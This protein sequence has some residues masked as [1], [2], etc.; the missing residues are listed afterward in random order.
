MINDNV[1]CDH[2]IEEDCTYHGGV[3]HNHNPGSITDF[4]R[5]SEACDILP[6]CKYWVYHVDNRECIAF[7]S[8]ERTCISITGPKYPNIEEC[9][10]ELKI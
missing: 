10:G 8:S 6:E 3:V 7:N 1:D 5:C 9:P 4:D 2:F